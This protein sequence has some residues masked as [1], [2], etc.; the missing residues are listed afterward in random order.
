MSL[1][2]SFF[3]DSVVYAVPSILGKM[4]SFLLVPLYTRVLAPADYGILDLLLICGVFAN[5]TV[6]LEISQGMARNYA[7]RPDK[8]TQARYASSALMFTILA[9]VLF[10]FLTCAAASLLSPLVTGQQNM[11]YVFDLAMAFIALNGIFTLSIQ[12]LRWSL[13]SRQYAFAH[14]GMSLMTALL[15][16]VFVYYM[17]LRLEGIFLSMLG[18]AATGL[19]IALFHLRG[20]LIWKIDWLAIRTML[21]FS[22]PL[23]PSGLA[24]FSTLYI[25]RLMIRHY[26]TM[27]DLGLYAIA[28]KVAAIVTLLMA[29]FRIAL[30]PLIYTHHKDE[31]TPKHLAQIFRLFCGF[32]LS[33]LLILS[34]FSP[35]ILWLL[36]TPEYYPAA[37]LVFFLVTAVVLSEMYIFMPGIDLERKTTLILKINLVGAVVS[38]TLNALFIPLWGLTGAGIATVMGYAAVF[39]GYVIYSQKY[40]PVPHEWRS[41][42]SSVLLIGF[43]CVLGTNLDFVSVYGIL[44][45]I[46]IVAAGIGLLFL[47][48]TFRTNEVLWIFS[49]LKRARADT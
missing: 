32:S 10:L 47:T 49:T 29:G 21:S 9:Y 39:T 11:E 37:G 18:G 3:K 8:E 22:L 28:F 13:L 24:V 35:E 26:M 45:K 2:Q 15:A 23:V 43:L 31:R 48:R 16:I 7:D 30:T 40:Y 5:L 38:L 20:L 34:L 14:M 25:D 44:T 46:L 1:L 19:A 12:Q 42:M 33:A 27:T 6:S 17:G 41:I 36:T 4:I